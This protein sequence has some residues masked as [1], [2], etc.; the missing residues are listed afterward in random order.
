LFRIEKYGHNWFHI[1][2]LL[3]DTMARGH[4]KIQSQAKAQE[5]QAKIKKQ[6]GHSA[7]DQKKAAMAGLKASCSV[8]R[9]ILLHFLV[10]HWIQFEWIFLCSLRQWCQIPRRTA[11]ILKTSIQSF[12]CQMSS[13]TFNPKKVSTALTNIPTMTNNLE[14]FF[15]KSIIFYNYKPAML[16]LSVYVSFESTWSLLN[17]APKRTSLT[18]T[19]FASLN[20]KWLKIYEA[21]AGF[22][23]LM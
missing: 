3:L 5:K 11:S 22:D 1:I 6:Q 15:W 8:C 20:L 16:Q 12:P 23:L 2:Y 9:V 18:L 17:S 7:N 14:Q 10:S 4:Q 21:H 13:R 19:N